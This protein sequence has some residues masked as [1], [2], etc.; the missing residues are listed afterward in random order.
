MTRP[1]YK[2]LE[3]KVKELQQI[4][5]IKVFPSILQF[6]AS[7]LLYFRLNAQWS[8]DFFDQG[9]ASL[10]GYPAQALRDHEACWLNLVHENDRALLL[11]DLDRALREDRTFLSVH[12]I[13]SE[14]GQIRWV[15]MRGSVFCDDEGRF[16]CIQGILNDITREKLIEEALES[17]SE[18][19]AWVANNL[20]D[21]IYIVSEDHRIK[22]MNQALMDLVGDQVG[23]LCYKALFDRDSICPWSVMHHIQQDSCGFQDYVLEK[24]GR[25]FQV[26]SFPIKMRDGSIGK[27]GQLRD[28]TRTKVLQYELKEL[29]LREEALASAA[30]VANVGIFV[31]QN[32]RGLQARFRYAN[33][34]FCRITGFE[35]L[36]LQEMSLSDIIP[37]G[38]FEKVVELLGQRGLLL[39]RASSSEVTLIRK[40]GPPVVA[41]FTAAA[42]LYRGKPA[43]T[44]FLQDITQAKRVQDSLYLS[45]RLA[46]IGKLAAEVAHE[47][48][49]P[50]TSVLTF[51]KLASRVVQRDRLGP[52]RIQSLKEYLGHMESEANRCAGI[53][54]N[55]LDFSRQGEI[56]VKENDLGEIIE[57]TLNVLRHRAEMGKIALR[58]S[59]DPNVPRLRCDY[60]RLQ[61]AL[62]NIF[63]NSI[64]A[65]PRGGVLAV[66]TTFDPV[67]RAIHID[68][69]DT[70]TGISQEN[71]GRIFEPFFTTK[72]ESKGVGLGLSVAYGI[73]RQHGGEIDVQ[74][75]PGEGALFRIC[76]PMRDGACNG[77]LNP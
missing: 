75:R 45:Q 73:I 4:I 17:E 21:G 54:R 62:I 2:E 7:D 13:I 40:E 5:N 60:K 51:T 72:A 3:Q 44:G 48:N 49:N 20:E 29:A 65:M 47:I 16:L 6:T 30:D 24:L 22:F 23:E 58:T 15:K 37:S 12:R 77:P 68:I 57:R 33:E 11:D 35:L 34:A 50:L 9:I 76:L 38:P 42:S 59:L 55:L 64:E 43:I 36:E 1:T 52:E 71:L 8:F 66:A 28:I 14:S 27:L 39:S 41:L 25:A 46:S 53:A 31:V 32:Y 10:T 61:Q 63:W 70:G 18:I 69:R 67:R 26:R 19:F 56:E 74:S